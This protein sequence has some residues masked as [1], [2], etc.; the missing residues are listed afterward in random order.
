MQSPRQPLQPLHGTG[1]SA[2]PA[3]DALGNMLAFVRAQ[4]QAAPG[5]TLKAVE[6]ANSVRDTF[7]NGL[8]SLIRE[9]HLGLLNLLES[10]P[11]LFKVTR[12]PKNDI[13]SLVAS[14]ETWLG[15]AAEN[16]EVPRPTVSRCLH[17]GNVGVRTTEDHLRSEFGQFG[18]I[19]DVKIVH[20]G[21]RRYAFVYF[22]RSE[23]AELA[24]ATLIKQAKWKGN[25]SFA[26]KEKDASERHS[27]HSQPSRHLWLG[28]VNCRAVSVAQLR[29]LFEPFGA[30]ENINIL[31]E[32]NCVFVDFFEEA[33]AVAAQQQM[34]GVMLGGHLIE[35]G[36]GKYEEKPPLLA[37]EDA[38]AVLVAFA[39]VMTT[40]RYRERLT[41]QEVCVR[42]LAAPELRGVRRAASTREGKQAAAR[43]LEVV[44]QALL[45]MARM[46][47][48]QEDVAQH[49]LFFSNNAFPVKAM[50]DYETCIDLLEDLLLSP[51][52]LLKWPKCQQ[53]DVY[54]INLTKQCIVQH[55]SSVPIDKIATCIITQLFSS[56]K[57][58]NRQAYECFLAAYSSLFDY[59][60][61]SVSIKA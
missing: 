58:L 19:E 14:E 18:R 11:Q 10:F 55:G 26:K 42:I 45:T 51:L 31:A 20:Q 24:R 25:V 39:A 28:N 16:C 15:D 23:D 8:L 38:D 43:N 6:L 2:Q 40:L 4:L 5:G 50:P 17:V 30:I 33:S 54:L 46:Y 9:R 12:I 29:A 22:E 37:Q 35:L 7:G 44:R 57:P 3:G 52:R 59:K 34:R 32:K 21:E 27:K 1:S 61:G 48:V 13:V 56:N 41:L 53:R 47:M 36:F 60:N 49:Q